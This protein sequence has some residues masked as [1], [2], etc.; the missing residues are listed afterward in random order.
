[1]K[2]SQIPLISKLLLFFTVSWAI[3]CLFSSSAVA[4]ANAASKFNYHARSSLNTDD[5]MKVILNRRVA[6]ILQERRS[7]QDIIDA[8]T[9][10]QSPKGS[11]S[12]V[13]YTTGCSARRANWPAE[14]HW[15]RLVA[16]AVAWSDS[17]KPASSATHAA[18]SLGM[19]WW[20]ARDITNIA[21]LDSGGTAN[22]PCN[23][24]DTTLWNTNWFSNIIGLPGLVGMTCLLLGDTLQPIQLIHCTNISGRAY[25]QFDRNINGAGRLTGA[26]TLDVAKIGIDLALLTTN[27]TLIA[28]AYG[29]VHRELAIQPAVKADGI[30]PDGS[31]GQHA[32]ILYNGNYGNVYSNDIVDLELEAKG[33]SFSAADAPRA[34]LATLFDGDRWMIFYNSIT[35]VIHW[36]FSVLGRFLTFPVVDNQPSAYIGI[37]LDKVAALGQAW[38]S[39]ALV[40][41]AAALSGPQ[42]SNANAGDLQGNRLFYS[43]DYMIHRGTNYVYTLKMT[44]TRTQNSECTNSENPFGF[45]LS[46]G[47]LYSYITGAEYQDV[48]SAFDWNL[49]PGITVDYGNTPLLCSSTRFTGVESFVGGA[50]DGHIGVAGMKFT[51]PK[52]NSF[53]FQKAWFFLQDSCY[54]MISD[55][56][57]TSQ[58]PVYS[59]LDQRSH[60]GPVVIDGPTLAPQIVSESSS[61]RNYHDTSSLWHDG[62]GY[63][64][65]SSQ[66][67]S[68]NLQVGEKM[69]DWS[70]IGVSTQPPSSVDMMTAFLSHN[71]LNPIAYTSFPGLSLDDFNSKVQNRVLKTIR[72][73]AYVSAIL[74]SNHHTVMAVFWDADGGSAQFSCQ[75]T[76]CGAIRSLGLSSNGYC[77]LIYN[78][79]GDLTVSDPTQTLKS[80]MIGI[81]VNNKN[82]TVEITLPQGGLAGSSV[83]QRIE[84]LEFE[85]TWDTRR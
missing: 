29:R 46:D 84:L 35:G 64:W 77:A 74:D 27:T 49:I 4:S 83:S 24:T 69:G 37:D 19:D 32:G 15:T 1:M 21:C 12:D 20:F 14:D 31:F 10:S 55:I 78:L 38:G 47:T 80:V 50:S 34:A 75:S 59:V 9:A 26:N 41:F 33:T 23:Q 54:V 67:V 39:R 5:D 30:K 71:S 8:W 44:S 22:C 18:I 28:D 43:N 40:D 57:S 53:H 68:L 56:K 42:A 76:T 70:T 73:D 2:P 16:M 45:H 7:T 52:T 60:N 66:D 85:V 61:E 3:C 81:Q 6:T 82:I 13:D 62:V 11:W 79:A 65:N 51:N 17:G 25:A 63:C 36:D 58:A 48:F 72:N